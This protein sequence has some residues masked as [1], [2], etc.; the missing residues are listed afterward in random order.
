[1]TISQFS[2]SVAKIEMFFQ[3]TA[4]ATG[5]AFFYKSKD[6]IFL[7]TNWH[8]VTGLNPSTFEPL[9]SQS[10]LPNKLRINYKQ[11][12]DDA[13]RLVKS[14]FID[15][16]LYRNKE[17]VW[18]EHSE[19]SN[20]DV[21]AIPIS[22]SELPNFANTCINTVTPQDLELEAHVGMDCFILGFPQGLF[23]A[24]NTPI[25]KRGSIASE[26]YE[27]QPYYIDSATRKGM[28]G[29][30]VIA[31]HTGIFGMK[32]NRLTGLEKIGT[33]QKFFAIYSWR[34]G[35]DALGFQLGTAWQSNVLDNIFS[36]ERRG[37]HPKG[38]DGDM[39]VHGSQS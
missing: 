23:G 29:S 35:D 14:H 4:G 20:V 30:P 17:P 7:V 11:W 27:Q 36:I 18:L 38:W 3:C 1:M 9:H 22:I 24:G 32:D 34:V 25:W 12:A 13:K 39:H 31:Q 5:T 21:V 2:M 15:I 19:G 6:E 26:P 16:P 8:N 10:L 37:V 33:V 28:S